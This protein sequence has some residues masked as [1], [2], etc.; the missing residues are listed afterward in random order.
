MRFFFCSDHVI[1]IYKNTYNVVLMKKTKISTIVLFNIFLP[2]HCWLSTDWFSAQDFQLWCLS[3]V[4]FLYFCMILHTGSIEWNFRGKKKVAWC[5][6]VWRQTVV[7]YCDAFLGQKLLHC[8]CCHGRLF[9]WR[10][11][12]FSH[13]CVFFLSGCNNVI[14]FCMVVIAIMSKKMINMSLNLDLFC[15]VF[16]ILW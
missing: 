9:W 15:W 3:S 1:S 8:E 11:K 6:I 10:V 12:T 13:S 7:N 5:E 4:I 16:F 2:I 14:Q